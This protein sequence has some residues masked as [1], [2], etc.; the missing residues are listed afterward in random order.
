MNV[1]KVM[2]LKKDLKKINDISYSE[3]NV[4]F[5]RFR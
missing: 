2:K 5:Y 1:M 3:E 4:Y